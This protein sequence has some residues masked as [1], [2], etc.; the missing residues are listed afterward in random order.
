[1]YLYSELGIADK[2]D[3]ARCRKE[4][5]LGRPTPYGDGRA[6]GCAEAPGFNNNWPITDLASACRQ[7]KS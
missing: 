6:C 4:A 7:L 3:A 5:R 2:I 1:M